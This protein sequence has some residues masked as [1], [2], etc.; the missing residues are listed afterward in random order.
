MECN[1]YLSSKGSYSRVIKREIKR[2][3]HP[4]YS[5]T[6]GAGNFLLMLIQLNRNH[7]LFL[8]FHPFIRG[9][10]LLLGIY[11]RCSVDVGTNKISLLCFLVCFVRSHPPIV[12]MVLMLQGSD[13]LFP[14]ASHLQLRVVVVVVDDGLNFSDR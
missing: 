12:M 13:L 1:L 4:V 2:E 3:L 10:C 5:G 6:I 11:Q 8:P 14:L 7:L 9:F